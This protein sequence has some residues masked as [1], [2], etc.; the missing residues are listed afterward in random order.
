MPGVVRVAGGWRRREQAVGCCSPPT[1][2]Y[3]VGTF[4]GKTFTPDHTGKHQ[5]HYGAFY[6]SQCFSR[7]PGGRVIQVGW[8]R[9]DMPNMPFNQAFSLPMDLTL[10]ATP[11][12]VRMRVQPIAE[13][14]QLRSA[15]HTVKDQPVTEVASLH[16]PT[17]SQ[18]LDIVVDVEVGTAKRLELQFGSSQVAYDAATGK[19]D[20][21]P[22]PLVDGRL[23]FRV[24]VDRPMYEVVGGAGHV[25]KT[26]ARADGGEAFSQID[27]SAFGGQATARELTVY[28][29]QSICASSSRREHDRRE[30]SQEK[31]GFVK[32]PGF[33]GHA[34]QHPRTVISPS[35]ALQ[36]VA[37]ALFDR[38]CGRGISDS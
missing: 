1:P 36:H 9:M 13:L 16:V 27:L 25:Y 6:A 7:M 4:D 17:D 11:D 35:P 10:H 23:Q 20:E 8:A 32:R 12:G 31:S 21:M 30:V 5:V 3:A 38:R 2:K 28:P 29:M 15:P 33:C 22:L 37:A 26:A 19:L 24:L 18:L 34:V 14:K